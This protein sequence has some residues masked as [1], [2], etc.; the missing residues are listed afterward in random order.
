MEP[1]VGGQQTAGEGEGKGG[2][3]GNRK[4]REQRGGSLFVLLCHRPGI[5]ILT[6]P[7]ITRNGYT[8]LQFNSNV[9][10]NKYICNIVALHVGDRGPGP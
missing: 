9:K 8:H 5:E 6:A 2:L 3:T 7:A 1:G 4:R 10:K